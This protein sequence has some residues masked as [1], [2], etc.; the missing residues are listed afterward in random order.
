MVSV[1]KTQTCTI[2]NLPPI[3]QHL[4]NLHRK[5][6]AQ[7]THLSTL[8]GFN[9]QSKTN[10]SSITTEVTPVT[11]EEGQ[12]LTTVVL[13]CGFQRHQRNLF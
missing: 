12:R 2:T 13:Y 5:I 7:S 6:A 9:T 10:Q 11:S 4:T 1:A 8:G 3:N